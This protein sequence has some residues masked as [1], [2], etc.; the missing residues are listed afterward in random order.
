MTHL[1]NLTELFIAVWPT[2]FALDLA[3]YLIWAGILASILAIFAGP[4]AY[5]RIQAR[6]ATRKDVGREITYSVATALLF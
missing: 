3:R 6:S 5:R 2:I 1:E 4:L